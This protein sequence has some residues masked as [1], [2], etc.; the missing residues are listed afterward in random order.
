MNNLEV[1][2]E[3]LKLFLLFGEHARELISPETGIKFLEKMCLSNDK[4]IA[5][6]RSKYQ[7]KIILNGNPK[8]RID[9]E[10]GDYCKRT[11]P[12]GVDLNRN[13]NSHWALVTSLDNLRAVMLNL[14]L[15][16]GKLSSVNLKQELSEI[17]LKHTS[18]M[19]SLQYILESKECTYLS[20]TQKMSARK[21]MM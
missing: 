12:N 16:Q 20:H 18:Q 8:S 14:K 7:L 15:T 6:L 19:S 17:P 13:W 21:I 1:E 3:P 9:V 10:K 11:N 5:K 4:N 2:S